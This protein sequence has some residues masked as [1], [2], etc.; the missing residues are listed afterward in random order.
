MSLLELNDQ[1]ENDNGD[2]SEEQAPVTPRVDPTAFRGITVDT[3]Y[4]PSSAMLT[5]VEG[6][7]WSVDYYSQL[8]GEDNEPTPQALDRDPPYQQYQRIKHMDL[9][10]TDPIN[11]DQDPTN[12]TMTVT[13]SAT[14]FP[15][16]VPNV[17]DMFTADIGDGRT[18]A[19]TVTEARRQTILRDSVYT[20]EYELVEE[21]TEARQEDLER[22][23]VK[24]LRYS[25]RSLHSGCGPF[26]TDAEFERQLT[27]QQWIDDLFADY[28]R[29]FFSRNHS[30]L[31]VPD[32]SQPTFDA[33][34]V[35]A[36]L[37]LFSPQTVPIMRRVKDL[38]VMAERVMFQTT[39][40]DAL[41]RCRE[42]ALAYGVEQ[43]CLAS[44]ARFAGR[45]T[46]QSL[47]YTGIPYVVFPANT[48]SDVDTEYY[49]GGDTPPAGQALRSPQT[50]TDHDY[51]Q[52]RDDGDLDPVERPPAIHP[53][54]QDDYY[55]F[56]EAFYTG[57]EEEQS[58]LELLAGEALNGEALTRTRLNQV[59]ADID[60]WAPLERFYYVPVVLILL[61]LASRRGS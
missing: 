51:F 60:R 41:L 9:K 48:A 2:G 4:V 19:F 26:V 45:P 3:N 55:V 34:V 6:S 10:V 12:R 39:V 59:L 50:Q 54:T 8:L 7:N 35:W 31:L 58:Q 37:Q 18:G 27:D 15:F 17:G 61:K 42:S 49:R 5:W 30:T 14:T 53:V 52:R 13:G 36:L 43:V 57:N 40:W 46:L 29:D 11:F 25:R 20:I 28:L 47:G 33:F 44:T 16:L 22:K 23:T 1:D 56:S 24:T 38:N 21:L 32:Q